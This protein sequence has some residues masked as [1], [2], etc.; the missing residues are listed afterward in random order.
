MI[1]QNIWELW[2]IV[3]DLYGTIGELLGRYRGNTKEVFVNL[4][5]NLNNPS[6]LKQSRG[7]PK[8]FS[9]LLNLE[10]YIAVR[11]SLVS[12]SWDSNAVILSVNSSNNFGTRSATAFN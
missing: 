11:D 6:G 4:L 7:C 2:K 9:S 5:H 3:T 8:T 12:I 10:S 1:L